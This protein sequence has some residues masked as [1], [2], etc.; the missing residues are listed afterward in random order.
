[1]DIQKIKKLYESGYS[2]AELGRLYNYD[3]V[4]IKRHLLKEN[5]IIRTRAQQNVISNSK[6][7]KKVNNEY[8]SNIDTVNKAWILGFMM[9]DGNVSK[10]KNEIRFN[11]SSVDREILEKIKLEIEI[12]REISDSITGNG[13]SFS[14][15]SW[16]SQQQKKDLAKFGIVPN[17]TYTKMHLPKLN[18]NFVLAF[19]LGYFDGDGNFS[20]KD[21]YCRFRICGHDNTILQEIATFLFKKYKVSYS[22]NK[23]KK[24]LWELSIS[25]KYAI[26]ILNDMYNLNSIHLKR[27]YDKF[28]EYK[29]TKS[30]RLPKTEE[31]VR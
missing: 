8:F 2:L 26:K 28:L 31:K 22:L 3:S 13:F 17:K 20:V 30:P 29:N 4:T 21:N 9:A 14:Y 19:I 23:D 10:S 7:A 24:D 18:D 6:R 15:L 5:V 1:M 16:T 27:K 12:E 25:T 11:L